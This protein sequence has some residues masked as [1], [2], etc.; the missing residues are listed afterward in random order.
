MT[1]APHEEVDTLD[2]KTG[3]GELRSAIEGLLR[4][5]A[6]LDQ[7]SAESGR[8]AR[9]AA[10]DVARELAGLKLP[11]FEGL[12]DEIV[13]MGAKMEADLVTNLAEARRPY[14]EEVH[15]LLALLAPHHGVAE[16]L[17]PLR[18]TGGAIRD[19]DTFAEQFPAG[20]A[21]RYVLDLVTS[22]EHSFTRTVD[23]AGRIQVVTSEHVANATAEAGSAL[24]EAHR[25]E[26]TKLLEDGISHTVELHGPQIPDEA[27]L[28]RLIWLKDPT[29][30]YSWNVTPQ[31]AVATDHWA[32][33]TTGGFTSPEALAKPIDAVLAKAK[34]EGG[35][36]QFL[37]KN[38][39]DKTKKVGIYVTAEEVDLRPGDASGYQAAGAGTQ[40]TS[41]DWK[42]ARELGIEN[43]R[44]TVHAAPYNPIETGKDPGALVVFKRANTGWKLV[45]CFPTGE[46]AEGS[47]RLEDLA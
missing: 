17:P 13:G 45:T 14:L 8:E 7:Q 20:F 38:T 11:G 30:E 27:Q 24:D 32:G 36:D 2:E 41:S 1:R 10:H 18:V 42:K 26:G 29:G 12:A 15:Q 6:E 21:R 43:G 47:K 28:A 25:E 35:I 16:T 22:V 4:N 37:N 39:K 33:T 9:D 5:C 19:A 40:E 34:P 31:G 3:R 23:E 46:Q 44:N